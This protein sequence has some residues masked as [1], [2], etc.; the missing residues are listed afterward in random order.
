MCLES[1]DIIRLILKMVTAR[2]TYVH[3]KKLLK[4]TKKIKADKEFDTVKFFREVK[5]KI[6]RETRG[7]TFAELK[8]Y[9]SKRKLKLSK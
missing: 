2:L 4:M 9:I 3:P 7:M 5:E 1:G 6:A 8:D